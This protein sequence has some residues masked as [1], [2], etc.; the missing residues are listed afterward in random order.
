MAEIMEP[1]C[2]EELGHVVSPW[3]L[4][5]R[6]LSAG[7]LAP[8]VSFANLN[9]III[10]NDRWQG[11]VHGEGLSATGFFTIVAV[12]GEFQMRSKGNEVH[13]SAL[14]CGASASDWEF[15]TPYG[16]NHWVLMIPEQKFAELM[17]LDLAELPGRY[18]NPLQCDPQQ[19]QR[20]Y[21][22]L[23]HIMAHQSLAGTIANTLM[24]GAQL[25]LMLMKAVAKLLSTPLA[26]GTKPPKRWRYAAYRKVIDE[27]NHSADSFTLAELATI[28]GVSERVLQLAFKD[29]MGISPCAYLRL[30]RF[31]Q[32]HADL[33]ESSG[34]SAGVGER[35]AHWGFIECGRAAGRY[36]D[37]FGE[38]P[39][40]T[41]SSVSQSS[42]SSL[43]E[44]LNLP[45]HH[46]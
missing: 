25:E 19:L 46:P 45:Q 44:R 29:Y 1:E 31:N 14:V 27:I 21:T 41:A 9:D 35:M 26:S 10:T 5:L 16:A 4:R 24:T 37:M 38:L 34:M 3:Q 22:L 8:R 17:G 42:C 20:F 32:L 30:C 2:I 23:Q 12:Q 28:A 11:V 36:R 39:S 13:R 43:L 7:E 15:T 6:Q 18:N 33:R 40:D